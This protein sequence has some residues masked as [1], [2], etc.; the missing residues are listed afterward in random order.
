MAQSFYQEF[1]QRVSF[2]LARGQK[3]HKSLKRNF[4]KKN[5]L[6][7][8]LGYF[9]ILLGYLTQFSL[10]T[11]QAFISGLVPRIFQILH[12]NRAQ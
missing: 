2:K 10:K 1:A 3:V 4:S 8:Q 7:N 5:R 12:H 9:T 6:L 11:I